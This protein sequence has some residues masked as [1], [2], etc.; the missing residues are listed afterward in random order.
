MNV[1]YY[2]NS[3]CTDLYRSFSFSRPFIMFGS[4]MLAWYG[5]LSIEQLTMVMDIFRASISKIEQAT[6]WQWDTT[7]QSIIFEGSRSYHP[8]ST[9]KA[10]MTY[11][12]TFGSSSRLDLLVYLTGLRSSLFRT[13]ILF[14][15]NFLFLGYKYYY[16]FLTKFRSS[17]FM[18]VIVPVSRLFG[19]KLA[20]R[21]G[22]LR[23]ETS[24]DQWTRVTKPNRIQCLWGSISVPQ[25]HIILFGSW[26]V[27]VGQSLV[28]SG[29][30]LFTGLHYLSRKLHQDDPNRNKVEKKSANVILKWLHISIGRWER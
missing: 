25:Q 15:F 30:D 5:A 21:D 8:G 24:K 27:L 10:L 3:L 13:K 9:G 6:Q 26:K 17:W 16:L 18:V 28:S 23:I 2:R 1:D 22:D 19:M 12:S 4:M 14:M 11:N 20:G 7:H 29:Q